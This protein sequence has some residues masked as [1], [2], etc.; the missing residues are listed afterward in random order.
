MTKK[1]LSLTFFIIALLA[2]LA[3]LW[4][5]PIRT[6]WRYKLMDR[7]M[8]AFRAIKFDPDFIAMTTGGG[9]NSPGPLSERIGFVESRVEAALS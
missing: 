9:K 2:L 8:E 5:L 6:I 1:L 4:P 3:L 7:L